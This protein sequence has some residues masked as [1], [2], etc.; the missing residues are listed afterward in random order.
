MKRAI[1]KNAAFALCMCVLV[2]G[3]SEAMLRIVKPAFVYRTKVAD[4]FYLM[5]FGKPPRQ[6]QLD[7]YIK[8][9][10]E[11]KDIP[12]ARR[13]SARWTEYMENRNS[14]GFRGP[15]FSADKQGRF[16]IICLGDS[17]TWDGWYLDVL[18]SELENRYGVPNVEVLNFGLPARPSEAGLRLF[19]TEAAALDPD[20]ITVEYA[21]NDDNLHKV[22]MSKKR[23]AWAVALGKAG[24]ILDH[25]DVY[26]TIK[27]A[28]Q[29]VRDR[30]F[31]PMH[32]PGCGPQYRFAPCNY[33]DNLE[34]LADLAAARKIKIVFITSHSPF[35]S[36]TLVNYDRVMAAVAASRGI[37]LLDVEKTLRAAQL[38]DERR[39][40]LMAQADQTFISVF[41]SVWPDPGLKQKVFAPT[42]IYYSDFA[43][44][45]QVGH[46]IIGSR[47]AELI[48]ADKTS[49]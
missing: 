46:Q 24:A 21:I 39:K 2:F 23:P 28:V 32:P 48:A 18:K 49:K 35:Y 31:D 26:V 19:E 38:T 25:L 4:R 33:R 20:V 11:T 17:I 42:Y 3:A 7:R 22:E 29:F 1:L 5:T 41:S 12:F 14:R 15:E 40:A 9:V 45:N 34:T 8:T 27:A 36:P 10:T 43:H 44:P 13:M 47:L 37:P 30:S 6:F 16:R